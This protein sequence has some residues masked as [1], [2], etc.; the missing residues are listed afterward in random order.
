MSNLNSL[1][2][3]TADYYMHYPIQGFDPCYSD[4]RGASVKHVN[5]KLHLL[6]HIGICV[7]IKSFDFVTGTRDSNIWNR[8][9]RM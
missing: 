6:E 9:G 8:S 4:F 1:R 3:V 2:I 7:L 5:R